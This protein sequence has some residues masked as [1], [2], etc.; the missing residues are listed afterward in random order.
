M[1]ARLRLIAITSICPISF[2]AWSLFSY[3]RTVLKVWSVRRTLAFC[4]RHGQER[5]REAE[6]LQG[7]PAS[8]WPPESRSPVSSLKWT[9]FS[10]SHSVSPCYATWEMNTIKCCHEFKTGDRIKKVW[11]QKCHLGSNPTWDCPSWVD[12]SGQA[13]QP[14]WPSAFSFVNGN[15]ALWDCYTLIKTCMQVA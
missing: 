11:S 14:L 9:L 6:G 8:E 3:S 12:N 1:W 13:V 4:C 2:F 10:V 15:H 5:M 7:F